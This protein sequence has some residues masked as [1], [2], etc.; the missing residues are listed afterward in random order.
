M[1]LRLQ[2]A[3]KQNLMQIQQPEVQGDTAGGMPP[4]CVSTPDWEGHKETFQLSPASTD[5]PPTAQPHSSSCWYSCSF[6]WGPHYWKALRL[7]CW[8]QVSISMEPL[9]VFHLLI[10]PR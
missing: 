4:Q 8:G 7:R 3:L 9:G 6:T 2:V 10:A 5:S 1:W